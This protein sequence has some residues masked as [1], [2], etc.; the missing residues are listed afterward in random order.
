MLNEIYK[1][2]DDIRRRPYLYLERKSLQLL[3]AFI[4]GCSFYY[5]VQEGKELGF[6]SKF[7]K[8]LNSKYPE[9]HGTYN[10]A[11]IIDKVSKNDMDAFDRFFEILDEFK[12][13]ENDL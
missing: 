4:S 8:F 12:E 3:H 11:N 7:T 10:W 6:T 9:I 1:L 2:L 13:Q 5:Y